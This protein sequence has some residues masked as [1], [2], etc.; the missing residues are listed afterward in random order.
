MKVMARSPVTCDGYTKQN[1]TKA[2]RNAPCSAPSPPS[3]TTK[4]TDDLPCLSFY[5]LL[6]QKKIALFK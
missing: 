4:E 3:T 2:H 1:I 5:S 6:R